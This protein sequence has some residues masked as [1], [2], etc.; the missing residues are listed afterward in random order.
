[1]PDEAEISAKFITVIQRHFLNILTPESCVQRIE[2]DREC[3]IT[4]VCLIFV[5][6]F[7]DVTIMRDRSFS[8]TRSLELNNL[9]LLHVHNQLKHNSLKT[10]SAKWQVLLTFPGKKI[11][12]W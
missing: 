5:S 2:K 10:W 9:I 12:L 11:L 6:F 4:E 8:Y 1:M 3:Q 7:R